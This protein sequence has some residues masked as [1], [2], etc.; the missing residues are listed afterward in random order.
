MPTK[1]H[2]PEQIVPKLRQAEVHLAQGQNIPQACR[3]LGVSEQTY[4]MYCN[5]W[6]GQR[7]NVSGE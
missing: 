6:V 5:L 4:H 1:R 7:G 2:T 3:K